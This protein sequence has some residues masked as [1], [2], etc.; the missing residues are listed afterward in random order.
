MENVITLNLV[1]EEFQ[2]IDL[3]TKRYLYIS[4]EAHNPNIDDWTDVCY[5][6]IDI[7]KAAPK[8]IFTKSIYEGTLSEAGEL[9]LETLKLES[10]EIDFSEVEFELIGG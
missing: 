2:Q 6:L 4:I 9:S 3:N 1:T 5:V 8:A 10:S 7:I